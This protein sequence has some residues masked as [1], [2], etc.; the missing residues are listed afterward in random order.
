MKQPPAS[1]TTRLLLIRHG[2]TDANEQRPYVLQGRG[3]NTGLSLTGRHQAERVGEFLNSFAIDHVYA[4]PLTR[5]VETAT[6]I[7]GHHQLAVKQVEEIVECDVGQWEGMDWDSI[8]QL[9]P[10]AYANFMDNPAE[11]AYLG[12][13]SYRDVL[14]R[15]RPAIARLLNQHSGETIV[16]VAHNV[17]NRVYLAEL[18]G[19]ELRKA[20]G[21]R[22]TNTGVNIVRH[23]DGETELLT[24][25]ATFHLDS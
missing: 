22:Q 2:A 5:A 17:V 19:L 1:D 7:A 10:E 20:K 16:V 6:A 23:R 3:V 14:D 11:H 4:S 15:V 25:N 9:H 24:L 21:I 13:E 8:M 12:G 18:M